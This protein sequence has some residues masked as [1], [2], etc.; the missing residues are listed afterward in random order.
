[1]TGLLAVT[2]FIAFGS[3]GTARGAIAFGAVGIGFA[4]VAP[5]GVVA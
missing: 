3:F 4:A 5:V 1:V 2:S